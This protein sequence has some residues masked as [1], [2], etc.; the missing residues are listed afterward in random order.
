MN[1]GMGV[2]TV[3]CQTTAMA[4]TARKPSKAPKRRIAANR[5]E[6]RA[7]PTGLR[8]HDRIA[9]AGALEAHTAGFATAANL[10]VETMPTGS[11]VM[12]PPAGRNG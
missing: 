4:L 2:T 7:H 6:V 10:H 5:S 9:A 1:D 11:G 3:C 12:A 8:L